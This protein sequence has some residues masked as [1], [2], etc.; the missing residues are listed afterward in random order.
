LKIVCPLINLTCKNVA[1]EWGEEQQVTKQTLKDAILESPAL[2]TIDYEC[3]HEVILVVDTSNI[4]VGYILIQVGKDGKRYPSRFGSISLTEV[5]SR[6]SQAKLELYDLFHALCMVCM[7]IF[8][9]TNL[10]VEVNAKYIKGIINN[11]DLQPNMTI[12]QWIVGILLFSFMLVHVPATMH[13][14]TNS[15]SRRQP[16]KEDIA[17]EDDNEDWLD[18]SYSFGIKILNNRSC[19][20]AGAG[21]DITHYPYTLPIPDPLT[22]PPTFVAL[23][24]TREPKPANLTIPHSDEAQVK[25]TRIIQ[26]HRFL[27]NCKNP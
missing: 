8:S 14:G 5:K 13:T 12:N 20:I 4:A 3:G 10:M 25:D 18:H 21:F 17:E 23:L 22:H 1:F 2:H 6:Y 24:D 9:I 19:A 27:E 15:L 16:T 26:I 11:P 7:H